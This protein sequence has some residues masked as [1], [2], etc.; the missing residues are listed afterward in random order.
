MIVF[1]WA[2]IWRRVREKRGKGIKE[3]ED[4]REGGIGGRKRGNDG[5]MGEV[6]VVECAGM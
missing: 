2:K 6:V 5:R 1:R 3:W 4:E